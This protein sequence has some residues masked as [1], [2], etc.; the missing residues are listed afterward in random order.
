MSAFIR[1]LLRGGSLGLRSGVSAARLG[2]RAT[3]MLRR[4]RA[5]R[6]SRASGGA[7]GA[8]NASASDT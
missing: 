8:S 7:G 6:L 1:T 2:A 3:M 4:R 5:R